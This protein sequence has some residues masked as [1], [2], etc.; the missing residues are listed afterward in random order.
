MIKLIFEKITQQREVFFPLRKRL[1]LLFPL[2]L[3]LPTQA[4]STLAAALQQQVAKELAQY[5]KQLGVSGQK[6]QIELH[7]A[8]NAEQQPCTRWRF[9]R[10]QPTEP[11]LGRLSYRIECL[12]PVT[13][14]GRATAEVKFWTKVVVAAK[15]VGRDTKLNKSILTLRTQELGSLNRTPLFHVND[16]IGKV[17]RRR[18]NRGD[19]IS[20]FLLENPYIISRGDLVTLRIT[21]NTFSAVTQGTA[22]ED[23]RQ[24][25][26][27]K[28]QNNSSGKVLQGVAQQQG[29]VK[30]DFTT[31]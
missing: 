4:A 22:L 6:Q 9:E 12:A 15:A 30:I 21:I 7:F 26:R 27:I 31:K 8:G 23:A 24:G 17:T 18:L 16:A 11:P 5:A 19:V 20:P 13:W 3:A 28:V 10:P 14:T 29:L 1:W 25:E 2:L